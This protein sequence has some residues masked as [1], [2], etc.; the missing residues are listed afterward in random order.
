MIIGC[1]GS[2]KSTL[3]RQLGDLLNIPVLHLDYY[4]WKPNWEATEREE[5]E[6]KVRQLIEQ[7][8]WIMDGN[9]GGTMEIRIARADTIIYL[10]RPRFLSLYRVIKRSLLNY[11]KNR[12]DMGP[13]C[14]DHLS[15]EFLHYIYNY[16]RTRR[17]GILQKLA[18][19]ADHKKVLIFE[20]EK[21][22]DQFLEELRAR[23]P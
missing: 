8:A 17:P 21:E 6:R 20:Q 13:E 12:P 15:W 16:R 23:K 2:G 18:K 11:G 7:P 19:V 10:D 4:Y 9:Y 1:G 3:A 22:I 5:W 14:Y